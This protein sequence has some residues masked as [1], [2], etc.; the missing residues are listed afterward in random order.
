MS[1]NVINDLVNKTVGLNGNILFLINFFS[2]VKFDEKYIIYFIEDVKT[3]RDNQL[4]LN[5]RELFL[6]QNKEF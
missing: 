4:L 6:Q 3:T 5:T 2:L 1:K